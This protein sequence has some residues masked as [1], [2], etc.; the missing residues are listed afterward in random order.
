MDRGFPMR[1]AA[2]LSSLVRSTGNLH[3]PARSRSSDEWKFGI[4]VKL[5][6]SSTPWLGFT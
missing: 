6:L 2:D 3:L 1:Y 4:V 5:V